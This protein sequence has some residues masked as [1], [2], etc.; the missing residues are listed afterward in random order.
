[1]EVAARGTLFLDEIGD[2]PLKLQVKLLRFLQER[3][4]ERV[5][6]SYTRKADVRIIAATNIDLRRAIAEGRFREDLYYRL[7]VVPIEIPPLRER[8]EDVE[9]LARFLLGRV[10]SRH[11]RDLR[12]SP[13]AVRVLL[14]YSWPGNVREL[15]N[16]IEYAVAVGCGQTIQPEDLPLEVLEPVIVARPRAT[17]ATN[18]A[19]AIRAALER[20]HW[21]R[22]ATARSLGI[23]RTT[24]WR[25]MRE[26]GLET[27]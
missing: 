21:Q 27:R 26:A 16:A 11:G 22:D 2:L 25:K 23:S 7:R 12:F 13:D 14:K 9:P 18:E 19:E 10:A 6:D 15:E 1:V 24:L 17:Q 8:R 4:F 3:T 20:N 5:G